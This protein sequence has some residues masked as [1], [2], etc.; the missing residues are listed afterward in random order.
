[1]SETTGPS[2]SQN[3]SGAGFE[4]EVLTG[5][6][7]LDGRLQ[8]V[9]ALLRPP[10]KP[11]MT[12]KSITGSVLSTTA[13]IL[14]TIAPIVIG[15]EYA[16]VKRQDMKECAAAA[17]TDDK[18]TTDL[19]ARMQLKATEVRNCKSP[20]SCSDAIL[21]VQALDQ[22]RAELERNKAMESSSCGSLMI[23]ASVDEL[24]ANTVKT[25]AKI[26]ADFLGK[27]TK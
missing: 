3:E 18:A 17:M 26:K 13:R 21:A 14:M 1:M 27:Q 25:F 11:K 23:P 4:Q 19:K 9:E 2:G 24:K 16:A 7:R 8:T 6:Q 15:M 10:A 5:L 20:A 12:I 22:E